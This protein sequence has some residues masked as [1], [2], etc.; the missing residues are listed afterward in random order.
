MKN[1]IFHW[2]ARKVLMTYN[3]DRYQR[4][5]QR[6][7]PVLV[8]VPVTFADPTISLSDALKLLDGLLT[9]MSS[10]PRFDWVVG[11]AAGMDT[12]RPKKAEDGFAQGNWVAMI[13]CGAKYH[14]EHADFLKRYGQLHPNEDPA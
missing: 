1:G 2:G 14:K 5:V 11:I 7:T 13:R 9:K 4:E 3:Q 10:D 8:D 12:V 6:A